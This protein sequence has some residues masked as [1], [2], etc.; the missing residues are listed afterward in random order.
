MIMT[1][2]SIWGRMPMSDMSPLRNAASVFSL[3]FT[4]ENAKNIAVIA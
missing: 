3:L 1:T 4:A 2:V